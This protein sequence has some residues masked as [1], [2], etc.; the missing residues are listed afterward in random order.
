M[1]DIL[2]EYWWASQEQNY[3]FPIKQIAISAGGPK[4]LFYMSKEQLINVPGINEG[5]ARQ[6]ISK[7][8]KWDLEGEYSKCIN[9]NIHFIPYHNERYPTRLLNISGHPYAIFL[10]GDLPSD[11]IPS[12]AI[13]GARDCSEYGRF[14]ASKFGKELG[15][16]GI[17][18]IS[19]MAYGIDGLAQMASLDAGGRSFGVLGCG[20][21]LCYPRSNQALY[22][23]LQSQGGIISEYGIGTQPKPGLFPPRNRIISALSDLI[24]VVE[25]RLKS[26]TSITIDM[27]LEQGKEIGVVPGRITDSLSEG[28]NLLFKQG[29][30][31]IVDIEDILNLLEIVRPDLM[32]E[33]SNLNLKKASI[34]A[35]NSD[36]RKIY[37]CLDISVKSVNWIVAETQL[38]LNTAI[39]TL[40]KLKERGLVSELSKGYFCKTP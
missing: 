21:D 25:A 22:N 9:S 38:N 4:E 17:Q 2:Y 1:N 24:I 30:S 11:N 3:H 33:K 15:E 32:P 31:P 18:V 12:V 34:A 35:L 28:C 19:G 27:A 29:A 7:R 20:V 5:F 8:E 10:K 13:I 23:R 40:M 36:E 39:I 26:G 37:D 14:V 16:A 6:I